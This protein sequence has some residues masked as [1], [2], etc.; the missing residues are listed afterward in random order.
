VVEGAGGV[1]TD[2]NGKRLGL[3]SGDTVLAAGC[4]ALHKAALDVLKSA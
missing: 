4:P 1:I 2:F 3:G